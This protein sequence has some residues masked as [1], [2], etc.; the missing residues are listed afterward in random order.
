M[1]HTC[2]YTVDRHHTGYDWLPS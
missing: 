2:G 1:I